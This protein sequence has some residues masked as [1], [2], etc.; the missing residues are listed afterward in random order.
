MDEARELKYERSLGSE[1]SSQTRSRDL[2]AIFWLVDR[3]L[4]GSR[5]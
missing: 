2:N 3:F 5:R 4:S 1:Y